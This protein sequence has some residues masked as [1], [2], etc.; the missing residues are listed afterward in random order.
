M[1]TLLGRCQFKSVRVPSPTRTCD[2][3]KQSAPDG[4]ELTFTEPS[5]RCLNGAYN[6][7][8]RNDRGQIFTGA[9]AEAGGG[10]NYRGSY[11]GRG[12]TPAPVCYRGAGVI[13]G[14]PVFPGSEVPGQTQFPLFKPMTPAPRYRGAGFITGYRGRSRYPGIPRYRGTGEP[15]RFSRFKL[16]I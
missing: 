11:R 5:H 7:W 3:Y 8:V 2:L 13:P 15:T 4:L 12:R 9:G 10:Q 6:H 14:T 16:V 1:E